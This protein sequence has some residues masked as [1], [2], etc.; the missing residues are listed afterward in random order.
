MPGEGSGGTDVDPSAIEITNVII[1]NIGGSGTYND[2]VD[3]ISGEDMVC[4]AGASAC[5]KE[6]MA[7]NVHMIRG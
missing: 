2:V 3:M 4:S 1:S 7:A 5:M 6:V